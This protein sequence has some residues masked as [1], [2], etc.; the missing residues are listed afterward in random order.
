MR[1]Y[2]AGPYTKTDPCENTHRAI[3]AA[4]CLMDLGHRPF[5]PHLTHF[6]HTMFP[7][8]YQDWLELDNAFLPFCEAVVR[9]PGESSGADAEVRLAQSLGIPVHYGLEAFLQEHHP[10]VSG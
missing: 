4:N 9:L 3:K 7:R 2:V 5:V 8:P 6:W 10:E 1:I